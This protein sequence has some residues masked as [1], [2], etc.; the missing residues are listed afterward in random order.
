MSPFLLNVSPSPPRNFGDAIALHDLSGIH[1]WNFVRGSP[2]PTKILEPLLISG[3]VNWHLQCNY[4]LKI[5][6]LR[7]S[8]RRGG[9]DSVNK[10]LMRLHD[11]RNRDKLSTDSTTQGI[12]QYVTISAF[13]TIKR[14][15]FSNLRN[16]IL[17]RCSLKCCTCNLELLTRIV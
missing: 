1:V 13:R 12:D 4:R 9:K 14:H 2:P 6:E 7:E 3:Y 5:P 17:E 10:R 16:I 15:F 11:L 8:V